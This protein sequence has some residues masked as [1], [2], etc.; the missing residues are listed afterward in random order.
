MAV[1]QGEERPAGKGSKNA[2]KVAALL[3]VLAVS[4][5]VLHTA[6]FLRMGSGIALSGGTRSLR[7][8]EAGKK[9]SILDVFVASRHLH[10]TA[11][12]SASLSPLGQEAA[13]MVDTLREVG[14]VMV[15]TYLGNVTEPF[16]DEPLMTADVFHR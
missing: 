4:I 13:R 6:F 3:I 16:L 12:S 14:W 1:L 5:M 7:N 8:D 15:L 10:S 11:S 9:G 2:G